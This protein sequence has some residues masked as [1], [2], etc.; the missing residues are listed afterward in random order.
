MCGYNF[1]KSS[2]ADAAPMT[3]STAA[4]EARISIGSGFRFG[5]GFMSAVAIFSVLVSLIFTGLLGAVL[6]GLLRALPR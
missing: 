5:L 3:I 1:V 2:A 4:H 6:G